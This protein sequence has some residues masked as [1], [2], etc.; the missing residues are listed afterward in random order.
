MV[1]RRKVHLDLSRR[2][3]SLVLGRDVAPV[4]AR[5]LHPLSGYGAG[6]G[7]PPGLSVEAGGGDPTLPTYADR[8]VTINPGDD[9]QTIINANPA[10]TIFGIAA[11]THSP[12]GVR[13]SASSFVGQTGAVLN[14]GWNRTQSGGGIVYPFDS[15]NSSDG[16]LLRS[17]EIRDYISASQQSVING[18][19]ANWRWDD[20]YIHHHRYG[21]IKLSN[22]SHLS[23]STVAY[24]GQLN[25]KNEDN[26]DNVLIEDVITEYGNWQDWSDWQ[27]EGGGTKFPTHCTN[28]TVRRMTARYNRGGGIWFD[29]AD[30]GHLIEDCT[31]HDNQGPGIFYEISLS[32]TIRNNHV[33]NCGGAADMYI[34]N[35]RGTSG[36]PV[37]VE[38][39]LIEA[40]MVPR[41]Y[42]SNSA[43]WLKDESTRPVRLGYITVRNNTI[44]L[45]PYGNGLSRINGEFGSGVSAAPGLVY[46]GNDYVADT[47]EYN[48]V[49]GN[50]FQV[51]G[52]TR[53]WN[54]WQ[55]TEG[56]DLTGSLTLT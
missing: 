16:G 28:F 4:V 27:W 32:G 31:A 3:R 50:I 13:L 22:N 20:L 35:S 26:A 45:G 44:K 36:D 43:L 40:G 29:Y 39:N 56:R 12:S 18:G 53:N 48:S 25:I 9:W 10:G 11:G 47:N 46:T 33:W 14:G 6:V 42:S 51:R 41:T 37:I 23:N 38:G 30:Y 5:R 2:R 17:V 19:L 34:S 52:T 55:G 54:Y 1:N 7:A 8:D 15:W 24:C 21:G 49:G